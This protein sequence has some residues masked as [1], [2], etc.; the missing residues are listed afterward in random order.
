M[1]RDIID[2][3]KVSTLPFEMIHYFHFCKAKA[4]WLYKFVATFPLPVYL[5]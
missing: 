1:T 4:A 3:T 2:K 5:S